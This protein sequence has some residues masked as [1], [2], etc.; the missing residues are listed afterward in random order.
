MF[1]H[2]KPFGSS[3]LRSAVP[4][5]W[6]RAFMMSL[7]YHAAATTTTVTSVTVA[8][9]HRRKKKLTFIWNRFAM[10]L[11][12]SHGA[13]VGDGV[14]HKRNISSH[15][16]TQPTDRPIKVFACLDWPIGSSH[17]RP[18]RQWTLTF[19]RAG[20]LRDSDLA[21]FCRT[22]VC[23][24]S[25]TFNSTNCESRGNVT[26]NYSAQRQLQMDLICRFL[27]SSYEQFQT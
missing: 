27:T 2:T 18:A 9:S 6:G 5:D 17:D 19:L 8:A 23:I 25:F 12:Q 22:L 7:P 14:V 20:F 16:P 1:L 26:F 13:A 21:D 15:H 3:C 24:W 10:T 11:R 4:P